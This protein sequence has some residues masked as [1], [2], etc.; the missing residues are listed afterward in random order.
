MFSFQIYSFMFYLFRHFVA[1]MTQ[2]QL[3]KN[4]HRTL[5][6]TIL[7][8]IGYKTILVSKL[9]S[10]KKSAIGI[11]TRQRAEIIGISFF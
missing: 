8:E 3:V 2:L 10:T 6:H 7:T 1:M 11:Y 4:N 5:G 9:C